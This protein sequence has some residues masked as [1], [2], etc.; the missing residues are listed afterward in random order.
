MKIALVVP[1]GVDR[2]GHKVIPCLLWQ[3]ERLA[4]GGDEVHVFALGQEPDS[5][6][7][8]LLGA[9]VHNI[10]PRPRQLHALLA[11][12]AEH[13]RGRFDIVHSY[14]AAGPGVAAAAFSRLAGVPSVLTLPGGDLVALR[15]IGY[16]AQLSLRGRI[17]TRI[18]LA[19]ARRV[20]V[21]SDWM[22]AKAAAFGVS[23][24]QIPLGV[25]I[26]RWP[27]SPPRPRRPGRPLRL[28]Q[29]ANLN[30]VKDQETLLRA[31]RILLER[32]VDF[33]LDIIGLDTLDGAVQRRASALGLHGTVACRGFLPHPD[34]RPWVEAA[35]LLVVSSRHEAGPVVML[36]AAVAGVPTV[37]T[38]VGHVADWSPR[39]A[40]AVPIGD[41]AA[42]AAAIETLDKDE[43][44]RLQLA[45]SAQERAVAED[46]CDTA[47]RTRRLY[48][49]LIE[50][51]AR[52]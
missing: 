12:V 32:G 8:P 41:S 3:I 36:E 33:H 43:A 15:D 29:V 44:V 2:S 42:L 9:E 28:I 27:V 10:G 49:E 5:G 45:R 30:L 50:A 7:W 20:V 51:R 39:A 18:A 47:R 19:G 34:I 21:Q 52:R 26:D 31:A 48:G 13:R 37:G 16:G 38:A 1:G 14:W 24:A 40:A 4:G 11:L 22:A 6:R 35:D 25:A 23:A 46:A 17:M